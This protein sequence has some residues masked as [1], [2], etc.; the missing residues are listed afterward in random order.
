MISGPDIRA[1]DAG[2]AEAVQRVGALR[3]RPAVADPD[4]PCRLRLRGD[5]RYGRRHPHLRWEVPPDRLPAEE[6][7]A[8]R[9]WLVWGI[10]GRASLPIS[11]KTCG[12]FPGGP[13]PIE[14]QT[15]LEA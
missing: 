5:L 8:M 14:E 2:G 13:L 12:P 11:T 1:E 7:S 9:A 10:C 15:L 3:Q 4:A 6:R